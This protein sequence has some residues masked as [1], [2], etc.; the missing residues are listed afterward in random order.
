VVP[1]GVPCGTV[2]PPSPPAAAETGHCAEHRQPAEEPVKMQVHCN[3]C[4]AIAAIE[5]PGPVA[6]LRP[7]APRLITAICP[8]TGIE[9]EIATPPPRLS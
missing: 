2:A 4:S 6:E 7:Q 3:G 1:F 9:P 5:P 8:V